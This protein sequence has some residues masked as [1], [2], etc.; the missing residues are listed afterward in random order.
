MRK[1]DKPLLEGKVEELRPKAP[2]K[3]RRRV[4][5]PASAPRPAASAT[6]G[7]CGSQ[8]GSKLR[9]VEVVAGLSDSRFTELVSGELK[10]GDKLVMGIEVQQN[11]GG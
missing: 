1:E 7:T 11:W 9:A 6:R 2:T 8:D 4:F 3:C 10:V 5:P